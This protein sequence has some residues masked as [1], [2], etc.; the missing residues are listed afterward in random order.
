MATQ[1]TLTIPDKL[2]KRAQQ[3]A[4]SRN[5]D[6]VDVLVSS[7]ILDDNEEQLTYEPDEAV[8]RE[9]A[10]YLAMHSSLWQKYPNQHVAIYQGNL[11]DQDSNLDVLWQRI[12]EKYPDQFVWV[13]TVTREPIK[14]INMPSFRLIANVT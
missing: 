9:K 7:I 14:T 10:A 3:L 2:Y 4:Q 6:V 13:A 11:I 8:E 5:R 12:D 1:I